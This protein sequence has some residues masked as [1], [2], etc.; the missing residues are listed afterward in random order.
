[1]VRVFDVLGRQV[2]TL[3]NSDV[4]AGT[5]TTEWD[6]LN[7]E[8]KQVESGIYYYQI[9]AGGKSVTRSMQVQK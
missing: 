6:G 9:Q 7:G 5:Y 4:K 8:G 2:R 1:M 3:I